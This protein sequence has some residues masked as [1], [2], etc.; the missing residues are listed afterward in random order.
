[1]DDLLEQFG[2]LVSEIARDM[3]NDG[4]FSG[5]HELGEVYQTFLRDVL[6][7]QLAKEQLPRALYNLTKIVGKLTNRKPIVLIDEYD[8]PTSYAVQNG[9]FPDVCP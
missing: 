1:M 8:T 3:Q 9:Y 7:G 5:F 4:Y 2:E 6:H